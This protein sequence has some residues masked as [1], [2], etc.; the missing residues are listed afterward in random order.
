MTY[1]V[2][3]VVH[4]MGLDSIASAMFRNDLQKV[5]HMF[6]C[7]GAMEAGEEVKT[8]GS[9]HPKSFM[10]TT[11]GQESS[12]G[13]VADDVADDFSV[14]G[15][16]SMASVIQDDLRTIGDMVGSC[17]SYKN[18]VACS[19]DDVYHCVTDSICRDSSI[20]ERPPRSEFEVSVYGETIRIVGLGMEE[21]MDE[22]TDSKKKFRKSRK[23]RFLRQSQLYMLKRL[24]RRK[25]CARV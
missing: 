7:D 22:V 8:E 11:V 23:G 5:V 1:A 25:K 21:S 24:R 16:E 18:K 10:S 2:N 4:D 19:P 20:V 17:N 12:H 9:L 14:L 15:L 6:G 13:N 3:E